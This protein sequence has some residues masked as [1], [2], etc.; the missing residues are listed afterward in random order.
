[1]E[2]RR[3][4]EGSALGVPIDN[5]QVPWNNQLYQNARRVRSLTRERMQP[6]TVRETKVM[7]VVETVQMLNES[8]VLFNNGYLNLDSGITQLTNGNNDSQLGKDLDEVFVNGK[9]IPVLLAGQSI[10]IVVGSPI[11]GMEN[12]WIQL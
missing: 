1:M 7:R 2:R 3:V 10:T 9:K 6:K 5:G 12:E 11:N 4:L 8:I